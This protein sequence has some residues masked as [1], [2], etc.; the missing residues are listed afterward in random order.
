MTHVLR[1]GTRASALALTQTRLVAAD[2]LTAGLRSELVPISSRGD[3]DPSPLVD[4]AGGLA[5]TG[6]FTS[7]LRDAI[8]AR[9]IDVAVHSLKDL[10]V[11][12]PEG[13]VLAAVPGR[14]DSAD[15][16]V[17]LDG[18]GLADLAPGARIG[19]GSPRRAAML[20]AIRP[21]V[22]VVAVRGNVETRLGLLDPTGYQGRPPLDAVV[23]AAAGLARLGRTVQAERLV[24]PV[25]LPAPGQGALAVEMRADHPAVTSV[26]A[27]DDVQ[28]RRSVCAE[29][30]VLARLGAGCTAAVGA[31][32]EPAGSQQARGAPGA[33]QLLLRAVVVSADGSRQASAQAVGPAAEPERLGST[34][35]DQLLADGA[36][37]L[38][39]T[40]V[41]RQQDSTRHQE[42]GST[43]SKQARETNPRPRERAT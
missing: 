30:A 24:P 14:E 38:L 21:D 12:T 18:R 42:N 19:T 17:T 43:P 27:L 31:L 37:G 32:A 13:L 23:L 29:R 39:T 26:S 22:E 6:V 28:T 40:S 16:L 2:L 5:G 36:A 3:T 20:R 33:D 4:L 35:G 25:M 7:A 15:L 1:V 8:L 9:E 41:N 10:P 11:E 34:V